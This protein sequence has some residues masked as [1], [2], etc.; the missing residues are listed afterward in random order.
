MADDC[1]DLCGSS[2]DEEDN[3]AVAALLKTPWKGKGKRAAPAPS[4][5][6]SQDDDEVLDVTDEWLKHVGGKGSKRV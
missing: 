2:S 6:P 3:D 5:S 1:I 4:Q